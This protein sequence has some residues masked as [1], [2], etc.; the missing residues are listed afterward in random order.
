[1]LGC[2]G[3]YQDMSMRNLKNH[4]Y[5]WQ[6]IVSAGITN[7]DKKQDTLLSTDYVTLCVC[8]Q[9]RG[10]FNINFKQ[11]LVRKN[12]I[13]VLYD[14]TFLM[15]KK[16]SK[17]FSID[18]IMLDKRFAADVVF[19]LPN[20]LFAFFNIYP[21][22]PMTQLQS[23]LFTHWHQLLLYYLQQQ[24]EFS[25]LQLRHHLQNFF[26]E[27]A[28]Q[29]EQSN[30]DLQEDRSRKSQ[31]CWRFWDLITK[32]CKTHRDVKFYA[33]QLS[34]T[35]FYLSQITKDFFK[36]PPKALIDR[37]VVLEI[38]ALLDLGTLSI[39][40]IANELNFEDTS[41]LCRYFKRQTGITLSG[42]RKRP[43]KD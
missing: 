17:N 11:Y 28:N 15:L 19:V 6:D 26:L 12:D 42:F 24:S 39:Q 38:K 29:V 16:K 30:I 35:P 3:K 21:V 1:M 4:Q 34:I 37:Q 2:D 40:G 18:Y 31:L 33:K 36:D 9:G 23:T 43:T 32:H 14:D 27:I 20:P 5:H 41:Y 10:V 8:R 7:L 22:L 25:K 13:L